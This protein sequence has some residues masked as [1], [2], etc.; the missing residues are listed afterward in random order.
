M[1][2]LDHKRSNILS[3]MQ[4]THF[5][6]LRKK[7]HYQNKNRSKT[8]LVYW[9]SIMSQQYRALRYQKS[10]TFHKKTMARKIFVYKTNIDQNSMH[11]K[12]KSHDKSWQEQLKKVIHISKYLI[13]KYR[14]LH[15]CLDDFQKAIFYNHMHTS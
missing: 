5:K 7:L 1:L 8:K 13:Y 9:N 12:Y 15:E 2:R 14:T 3:W 6:I 10:S 11:R 4:L